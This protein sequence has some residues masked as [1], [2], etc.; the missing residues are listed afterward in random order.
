MNSFMFNFY[1]HKHLQTIIQ[2]SLKHC[3]IIIMKDFNVNI[4][5]RINK[6]KNK[7]CQG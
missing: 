4:P 7:K 3:P 1:I 5:Q 2:Q 6:N